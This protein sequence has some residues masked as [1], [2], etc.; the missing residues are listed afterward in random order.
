MRRRGWV[1]PLRLVPTSLG[2]QALFS[3]EA[4]RGALTAGDRAGAGEAEPY[5]Q[6]PGK[7]ALRTQPHPGG[8]S[9]R[10][11]WARFCGSQ[12][13]LVLSRPGCQASSHG[14]PVLVLGRRGVRE[15]SHSTASPAPAASRLLALGL[16]PGPSGTRGPAAQSVPGDCGLLT[17]HCPLPPPP[18]QRLLRRAW[19]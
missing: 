10:P 12:G 7:S 6:S 9:K 2:Q 13:G 14:V 8:G 3:G 18:Q 17:W 16:L 15:R 19:C 11:A 1:L 5:R 4:V